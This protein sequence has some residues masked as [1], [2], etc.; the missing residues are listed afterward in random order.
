MDVPANHQEQKKNTKD[1]LLVETSV[2]VTP[3]KPVSRTP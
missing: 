1:A 3:L 2:R